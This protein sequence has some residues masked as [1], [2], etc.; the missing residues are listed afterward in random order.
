MRTL[1]L[2]AALALTLTACGSS[3]KPASHTK[4]YDC[5]KGSAHAYYLEHNGGDYYTTDDGRKVTKAGELARIC[6]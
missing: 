2:I 5:P 3:D 4:R 1:G 6:D